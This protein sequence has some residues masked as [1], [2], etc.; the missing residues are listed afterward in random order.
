RGYVSSAWPN[1][2]TEL[3]PVARWI[4]PLPCPLPEHTGRGRAPLKL[5]HRLDHPAVRVE[6]RLEL[7]D[8]VAAVGAVGD[9][10]GRVDLAGLHQGDD[11]LELVR[12]GIARGQQGHLAAVEF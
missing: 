6:P 11:P 3:P 12:G 10:G 5:H 1:A 9:P 8:H 7:P 4:Y 2:S